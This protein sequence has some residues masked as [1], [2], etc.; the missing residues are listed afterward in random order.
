MR[1]FLGRQGCLKRCRSILRPPDG[2]SFT[3]DRAIGEI[4]E[5]VPQGTAPHAV[6]LQPDSASYLRNR[7]QAWHQLGET[8][9]AR[10][11]FAGALRL[12]PLEVTSI[13]EMY[14]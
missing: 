12:E 8:A 3:R 10:D 5:F 6:E 1:R 14:R 2:W 7:G 13:P 9:K 4:G 11:D